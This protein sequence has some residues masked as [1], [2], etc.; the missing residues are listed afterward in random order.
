M[1]GT[2]SIT[3]L[4]V[5]SIT[6]DREAF[7]GEIRERPG[8]VVYYAGLALTRLGARTRVVTRV[9]SDDAAELLGPLHAEGIETAPLPSTCTTTYLNDYTG[10]RDLHQLEATS[11]PISAN[12]IPPA[13]READLIHLGPLHRRDLLPD[14]P[15][16]LRGFKGIDLQGLAR[17][18]GPRGTRLAPF[19]ALAGFLG[20]VDAVQASHEEL[21]VLLEGDTLERFARRYAIRELIVTRG[22]RGAWLLA[23]GRRIEVPA[24]FARRAHPVGAGD[25]F[26]ASYLFLRVGGCDPVAAARGA[27]QVCAEKLERGEV[28]KGFKPLPAT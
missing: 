15:A 10:E 20:D 28:P 5:G 8:G 25:V 21:D 7:G 19:P 18:R 2:P 1:A 16:A 24:R 4:V 9:R 13:W 22:A 17:E 12:D 26:L 3:A 27:A 11:D 14:V 6:R 23:E